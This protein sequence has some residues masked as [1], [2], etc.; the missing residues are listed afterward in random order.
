MGI[1][2]CFPGI[3][4]VFKGQKSKGSCLAAS[5]VVYNIAFLNL[6]ISLEYP[7]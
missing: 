7:S 1:F 6:S 5:S 4:N 2:L 3:I